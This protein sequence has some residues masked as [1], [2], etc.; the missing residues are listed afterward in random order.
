M[1]AMIYSFFRV[2][3]KDEKV[4]SDAVEN[5]LVLHLIND[6][7]ENMC[8]TGTVTN[9]GINTVKRGKLWWL[10]RKKLKTNKQIKI[11]NTGI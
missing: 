10:V 9:T 1:D 8:C 7:N 6:S 2:T 5:Y 3:Q 11:A 4:T